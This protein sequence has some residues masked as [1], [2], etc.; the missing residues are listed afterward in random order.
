MFAWKHEN[1][2]PNL[3]MN[4]IGTRGLHQRTGRRLPPC[5]RASPSRPGQTGTSC[6]KVSARHMHACMFVCLRAC[7]CTCRRGASFAEGEGRGVPLRPR[8]RHAPVCPSHTHT[9]AL[10][11][12]AQCEVTGGREGRGRELGWGAQ[13][14]Q[15]ERE[16]DSRV[17]VCASALYHQNRETFEQLGGFSR[18][19]WQ[20]A[21]CAKCFLVSPAILHTE[22]PAVRRR[23]LTL[24]CRPFYGV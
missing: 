22:S 10:L 8:P 6:C 4:C 24:P 9:D 3:A 7:Q 18:L 14:R 19:P 2:N 1:E 16:R 20:P 21:L 15:A 5:W 12:P 13:K 23:P 17:G 11:F